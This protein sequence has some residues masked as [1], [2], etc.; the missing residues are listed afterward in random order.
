[1]T[2]FPPYRAWCADIQY[3]DKKIARFGTAFCDDDAEEPTIR[4]AVIRLATGHIP[5]GFSIVRLIPGR[6]VFVSGRKKRMVA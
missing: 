4:N 6:L 3:P 2:T 5:D 1:M